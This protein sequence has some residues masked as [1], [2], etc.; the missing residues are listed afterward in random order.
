M[1]FSTLPDFLASRYRG[2][3]ADL[4]EQAA[5]EV[6]PSLMVAVHSLHPGIRTHSPCGGP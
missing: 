3:L 6:E 5:A 4:D 1:S 2:A